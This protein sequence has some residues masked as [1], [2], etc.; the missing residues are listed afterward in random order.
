MLLPLAGAMID[1]MHALTA[2]ARISQVNNGFVIVGVRQHL[3]DK[4]VVIT[5]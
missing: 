5:F 2:Q 3:M 1:C 4:L